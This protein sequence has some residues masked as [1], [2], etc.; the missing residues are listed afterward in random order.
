MVIGSSPAP[1][2][3][4]ALV[5][6]AE[7]NGSERGEI[8]PRHF[9]DG[10]RL[11]QSVDAAASID[12]IRFMNIDIIRELSPGECPGLESVHQNEQGDFRV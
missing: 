9:R 3:P 10:L 6:V 11:V 7:K 12:E 2:S 5:L 8:A 4:P 1:Q